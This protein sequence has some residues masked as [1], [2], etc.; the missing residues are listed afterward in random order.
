MI[1]A[2]PGRT[3]R[4]TSASTLCLSAARVAAARDFPSR[5]WAG[6]EAAQSSIGPILW[7]SLPR[8]PAAKNGIHRHVRRPTI[9]RCQRSRRARNPGVARRAR[10]GARARRSGARA[11]PARAADRQG[12]PLR[13]A[14]PVLAE[15]RLHQHHPAAHGGALARQRGARGA[16]PLVSAAGT[17]WCWWRRR[18]RATTS[19]A[20]TSRASPRSARCSAP[21]SS[22]SGTRRTTGTAAT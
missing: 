10:G 13:R 5:I 11:L 4:C 12:A 2:S 14:H 18:T 1:T 21:A 9:P 20:A 6:M 16:H 22:T 19:S 7:L 8:P 17:R 15:H 3:P